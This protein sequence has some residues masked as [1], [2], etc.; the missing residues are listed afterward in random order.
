MNKFL[1]DNGFKLLRDNIYF[2]IHDNIAFDIIEERYKGKSWTID[3][4]IYIYTEERSCPYCIDQRNLKSLENPKIE[5][6][7]WSLEDTELYS[8][9][10]AEILEFWDRYSSIDKIKENIHDDMKYSPNKEIYFDQLRMMFYLSLMDD[11]IEDID[12]QLKQIHENIN[13]AF[14][15]DE[16]FEI[17]MMELA[18]NDYSQAKDYYRQCKLEKV[19]RLFDW[20]KE[21]NHLEYNEFFDLLKSWYNSHK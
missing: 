13:S 9:Y 20:I 8:K 2:R 3:L 16:V 12:V 7:W 1:L 17:K 4:S 14:Y 18:W 15:L 5:E 6:Y 21:N 11:S 10:Q 19:E